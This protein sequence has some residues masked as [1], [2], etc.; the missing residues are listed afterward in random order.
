MF[1]V[2]CQLQSHGGANNSDS[3]VSETC[4][5]SA[6]SFSKLWIVSIL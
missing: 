6:L 5:D 2:F 4:V 1:A 3:S